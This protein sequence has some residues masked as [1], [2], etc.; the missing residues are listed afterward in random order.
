MPVPFSG[1]LTK[2]DLGH[3]CPGCAVHCVEGLMAQSWHCASRVIFR[4][5]APICNEQ[6]TSVPGMQLFQQNTFS[7]AQSVHFIQAQYRNA[8]TAVT[9]HMFHF[10]A[11]LWHVTCCFLYSNVF[12]VKF[13]SIH[14]EP[15]LYSKVKKLTK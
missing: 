4:T 5:L 7:P 14:Q 6:G 13:I 8:T 15:K 11:N 9:L 1:H 10:S 12:S 3:E 2:S